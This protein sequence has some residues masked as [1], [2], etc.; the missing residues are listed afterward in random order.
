MFNKNGLTLEEVRQKTL[1]NEINTLPKPEIKTNR[2]IIF[3][4]VF[5]LFNLYNLVIAIALVY[6]Q[7]WTSLFFV[8]IM[9]TNMVMFTLQEIKSRNLISK[10]NIII[11]PRT[12][13]VRD[14]EM[15]EIDNETIVLGDLVYYES[16]DQISAD[17]RI[18]SGDVEVN[19]SLLTGEV[20]PV[21]KNIGDTVLSGSFIVSGGCYAEIINVGLDN[22]A[23]K[24]TSAVKTTRVVSSEL[25][26]TFTRVTKITSYFIIPIGFLLLYQ[27]LIVR[28]N[29]LEKIIMSSSTALMGMLPKGL[30][31]LTTLS[32]IGSVIK[33]GSRKTLVQDLYAIETL[34]QAS[35][36]CLDKTG[37]LT[38]GQMKVIGVDVLE[39]DYYQYISAYASYTTDNNA[40]SLA[41][42][43]SAVS[44]ERT[45][46]LLHDQVSFSSSR[47]WAGV[48]FVDAGAVLIGAPE[49]LAPTI[50]LPKHI[51][52]LRLGGARIIL[53]A[54][55]DEH[56]D[57]HSNFDNLILLAFIAIEDPIRE[58]AY[59]A[60][61]F[62][63]ENDVVAKVISGDHI[64]TVGAIA[65][66]VGIENY[67]YVIDA[68]KL[69]T[70]QD[71]EKA[72]LSANVIG[73][74][75]PN[76]KLRFVEI[77]QSHKEVVAMTGDGINDVLALKKADCSIAMGEGSDAALHISQIVVMDGLLSTLV[78]VVKQG[79]MV[80]NNITRS[81]SMYYLHTVLC[82]V[83]SI[84]AIVMNV[85]FPF[86]PFQI[87]ITNMFIDGWPSFMLL[88]QPN[89]ERPK[90]TILNHVLRHSFPNALTIITLWLGL[91]LYG[92]RFGL[93]VPEIRTM[94]F[95]IN[96]FVSIH[97]IYRI[98][99]PLNTYRFVVLL[100]DVIAFPI[101]TLIFWNWLE[102]IPL[103]YETLRL[104]GLILL[105]SVPMTMIY[106]RLILFYLNSKKAP[107]N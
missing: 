97:M 1:N 82:I 62:F 51:E 25:L 49:I 84:I 69:K 57:K 67:E 50:S 12:K 35:V 39:N 85:P 20:D 27:G 76:Q 45:K 77:L 31:L 93:D 100:V 10:L 83:L 4:Q 60:I 36:L 54:K 30:V 90:E 59:E 9:I 72:I 70:E 66:K 87:T 98:Y 78:D 75:T 18:L 68:S 40:T 107:T 44:Y 2:Q 53:V 80:I 11:S 23:I 47:K 94:M 19:E 37:T 52:E 14:G 105:V 8:L 16:G 71:L 56:V 46:L 92:Y 15:I 63:R 73:R 13:V 106:N 58:D 22:Y 65:R 6:V 33:L 32:L 86:I 99:K 96:G 101:A 7:A 24:I 26:N 55:S 91:N 48:N 74:A 61:R 102:L 64:E 5:T 41:I 104:T 17:A 103:D 38:L 42:V 89:Y 88:W 95:Y 34:S 43:E 79:R 21:E 81:A 28:E 29:S 3:G